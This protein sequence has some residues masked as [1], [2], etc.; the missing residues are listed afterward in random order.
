M[1]TEQRLEVRVV[2]HLGQNCR[3]QNR[4]TRRWNPTARTHWIVVLF[5]LALV[6]VASHRW[7]SVS[8]FLLVQGGS[9][10]DR[11]RLSGLNLARETVRLVLRDACSITK[12]VLLVCLMDASFAGGKSFFGDTREPSVRYFCATL[13]HHGCML[14][15]HFSCFYNFPERK[16]AIN[17]NFFFVSWNFTVVFFTLLW[18][19]GVPV[20]VHLRFVRT[21]RNPSR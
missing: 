15:L 19:I 3:D 9:R 8:P 11:A 1:Q 18:I 2:H 13:L 10:G 12:M 14:F 7:F 16:D 17:G 21:E 5:S 6:A 20:L 4:C